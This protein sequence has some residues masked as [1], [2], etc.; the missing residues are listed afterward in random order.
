MNTASISLPIGFVGAGNMAEALIGG[1]IARG[2][3]TPGQILISDVRLERLGELSKRF[4]V[5]IAA[6][7]AELI[8]SCAT[9]VFA[10]KPQNIS[11]LCRELGGEVPREPLYITILAGT[12]TARLDLLLGGG[13]RVVRVM[14]NTPALIGRGASGYAA[15]AHATAADLAAT[16]TLF[17][18]V[19]IAVEVPEEKLDL[20]TG[21][22]GS[23][24]AYVFLLIESLIEAGI[25]GGLSPEDSARMVKQM[26]DGAARLA[27]DSPK[28]P[29][30]LRQAVT[31][32][33][34]TTAAGLEVLF[35]GDFPGLVRRCVAR[36]TERSKE[37][38]RG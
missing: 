6:S 12:S 35:D 32:P 38:G 1:A 11:E 30:E 29:A 27:I 10:V 18:A 5:K 37:L 14:P 13:R 23:G 19:G 2:I 17:E 7:N 33:K 31:S 8:Q 25:E 3:A 15:G 21:L 34:G 4:G 24:P 22:T 28:S 26:V 16:R 9:V 36:A 20:V